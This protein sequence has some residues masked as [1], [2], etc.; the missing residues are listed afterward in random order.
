MKNITVV[1]IYAAALAVVIGLT[2]CGKDQ[3]SPEPSVAL[4]VKLSSFTTVGYDYEP[5]D[6]KYKF[7]LSQAQQKEYLTLLQAGRWFDPGELPARGYTPVLDAA[8]SEGWYL[9]VG[10]WDEENTIIG[11]FNNDE[12]ER[13]FY[14]APIEVQADARKFRERL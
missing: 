9:T 12:S 13:Y 7:E 1:S 10:Y 4:S 8:N 2:A 5:G 6:F 14:F 3:T 11:L